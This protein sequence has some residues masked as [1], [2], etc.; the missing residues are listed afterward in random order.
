[1]HPLKKSCKL[2]AANLPPPS[3]SDSDDDAPEEF[4]QTQA[5]DQALQKRKEER[6]QHTEQ[7]RA[8]RELRRDRHQAKAAAAAAA[9]ADALGRDD[10]NNDYKVEGESDDYKARHGRRPRPVSSRDGLEESKFREAL[11]EPS[12]GKEK[13]REGHGQG[14]ADDLV[15]P[16]GAD[17]VQYAADD[18]DF[19][20]ESVL[21]AVAARDKEAHQA[22]ATA[23]AEKILSKRL[24]R[25]AA[26][27]QEAKRQ[28][29]EALK[30]SVV[31]VA[32]LPK[33]QVPVGSSGNFLKDSLYG[34][35]IRRS[36]D[37]LTKS[38]NRPSSKFV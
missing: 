22:A 23:A 27:R 34:S 16:P 1:M 11:S 2:A 28:R 20:P 9:K 13:D 18:G 14:E 21:A 7:R 10:Q 30:E 24:Q 17:V 36:V 12:E 33:M 25:R 8:Q 5:R 31:A 26:K 6:H 15:G 4:T 37:M 3:S 38:T 19:L 35:R 32:V 29:L